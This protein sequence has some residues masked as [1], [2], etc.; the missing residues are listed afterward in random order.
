MKSHSTIISL[1]A[2]ALPVGLA[3]AGN[4]QEFSAIINGDQQ[5][6]DPVVTDAMGTLNGVYDAD[7][8]EFSFN[9]VIMGDLDGA[10]SSP[11]AHLHNGPAGTNGP[12]VFAFNNPDGTWELSGSATWTGLS[13]SEVDALFAGEIYANFHTDTFPGGEV[14]GQ[15]LAVP[16]PGAVTFLGM[17]GLA[18]TRRRR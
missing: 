4:L 8:N 12:V 11:G 2:I 17:G 15:V 5:V 16:T 7:L 9:W 10:P 14:R 6:P 1:C 3:S 18:L 13:Q